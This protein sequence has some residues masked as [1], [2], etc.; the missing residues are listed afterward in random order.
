MKYLLIRHAKTDANRLTRAVFG[1][2]GAPINDEGK[3]Q[4]EKLHD[5]LIKRNIDSATEPVVVSELLRTQQTAEL[6]GFKNITVNPLL[7]EVNTADPK[8]TLEL[9]AQGELPEE[10]I[11]AAHAILANPPK[12]KIW[13]TH[14]LVIAAIRQVLNVSGTEDLVPKHCEIVEID[15]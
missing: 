11:V 5:E 3:Q 15:F 12:Q 2:L 10:A 6:A 4:A 9:V 8:Q 13:V 1:K 14:G 7:N